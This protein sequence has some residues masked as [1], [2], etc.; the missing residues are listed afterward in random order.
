MPF[1]LSSIRSITRAN[2]LNSAEGQ[3]LGRSVNNN[4]SIARH[5]R[6]R[7][8]IL[9]IGESNYIVRYLNHLAHQT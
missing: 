5:P 9:R 6:Y 2:D 8:A 4:T 3:Q 1:I 7:K